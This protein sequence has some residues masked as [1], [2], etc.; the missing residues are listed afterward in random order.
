[1]FS[2]SEYV[3]GIHNHGNQP[4][5]RLSQFQAALH[6]YKKCGQKIGHPNNITTL[7]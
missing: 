4:F 7:P 2:L 3:V 5:Q 6:I 1:M